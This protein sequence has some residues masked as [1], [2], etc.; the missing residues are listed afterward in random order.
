[1]VDEIGISPNSLARCSSCKKLIFKDDKRFRE[2]TTFR[3]YRSHR[4][5]CLKCGTKE[6]IK[7]IKELEKQIHA[8]RELIK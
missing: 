7:E 2:D 5:Y 4:F 3:G 1:M 8:K 6:V